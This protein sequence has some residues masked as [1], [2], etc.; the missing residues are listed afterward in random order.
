MDV[1]IRPLNKKIEDL[2]STF[3]ENCPDIR[4]TKV[5]DIYRELKEFNLEVD[6]FDPLANPIEAKESY[7]M[8]LMPEIHKNYPI[9]VLAIPHFQFL[10]G[11]LEDTFSKAD[12]IF[13]IK[14]VL[15][16]R[17]NMIRV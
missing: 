3:K 10:D 6:I 12:L 5:L 14:W 13:D 11:G 7:N 9:V 2:D 17:I 8:D 4:N 1:K 16:E 15:G